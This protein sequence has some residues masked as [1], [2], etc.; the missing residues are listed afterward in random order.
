MVAS[1]F[2]EHRIPQHF[3]AG[4]KVS[5][6]YE[7]V[8]RVHGSVIDVIGNKCLVKFDQ[9]IVVIEK[10]RDSFWFFLGTLESTTPRHVA[11]EW[12][13]DILVRSAPLRK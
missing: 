1:V 12:I 10:I 8:V 2:D 13:S 9:P 11:E 5:V 6:S 4:D 3:A 7:S